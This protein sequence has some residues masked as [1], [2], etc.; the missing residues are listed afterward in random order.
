MSAENGNLRVLVVNADG[1]SDDLPRSLVGGHDYQVETTSDP[2]KALELLVSGEGKYHSV[3]V[4]ADYASRFALLLEETKRRVEQLE[5]LRR[6]SV[7][8]TGSHALNTLPDMI[9]RQA[10]ELLHARN[11]GVYKYDRA[12]DEL[13]LISDRE[14]PEHIGTVLSGDDGMARDLVREGHPYK[15]ATN[16]EE[17]A[18]G[19]Q[20]PH[21]ERHHHVALLGVPLRWRGENIGL[22]YV[23]DEAG[24][25]FTAE[26][27]RIFGLFADLT[28]AALVNA[29]LSV[30]DERRLKSLEKLAKATKEIMSD[31]DSKLLDARL[32][33]IAKH[34]A[35]ILDAE[36]CYVHL[37]TRP[38]VLSLAASHGHK[39]GGFH[40]G[41]EFIIHSGHKTGLIGHIAHQ[42]H[43]FNEH[44][45]GLRHHYA[46]R[47]ERPLHLRSGMCHSMV[48]NPLKKAG[49]GEEIL[50]GL[51]CA[52]NKKDADGNPRSSL[53]FTP[54]D[55]W[56]LKVFSEAIVVAL[57]SAALVGELS[58]QRDHLKRLVA[59]S[60]SG[61]IATDE[62]GSI[63]LFN[64]RAA[65]IL[66]YSER[67]VINTPMAQ[68]YERA[69]AVG[70]IES[71]LDESHEEIVMDIETSARGTSV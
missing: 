44:G 53:Q 13:V 50:V 7:A 41:K 31:L 45:E 66:G 63:K 22:A 23:E 49:C 36:A 37:V 2:E 27:A 9:I 58:E 32:T 59:S 40:K 69:E 55:E 60:P 21:R 34:T 43:L 6:T 68:L 3:L 35:D 12:S 18:P 24:R 57:D 16:Y 46:V 4:N 62:H 28:A 17:H 30:K 47:G 70:E 25:K 52:E 65:H 61:I 39:E 33:L 15:A 11:G 54:E 38:G 71:A 8:V 51:L 42:G 1:A 56:I 19:T 14:H 67:E 64:E 48:A 5:T 20:D 26:D 29:E 10:V